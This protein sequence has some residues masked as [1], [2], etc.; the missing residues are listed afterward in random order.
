MSQEK[1]VFASESKALQYLADYTQSRIVIAK[2]ESKIVHWSED[3]DDYDPWVAYDQAESVMKK[4]E[5]RP[6]RNKEISFIALDE[7]DDVIGAAFDSYDHHEKEYSFDV[8]V[9]PEYR[10]GTGIKLIKESL[11]KARE[12]DD[13]RIR[14][15]VVNPK[16]VKLLENKFGF[17]ID[18]QHSDGS[19]HMSKS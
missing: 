19:A 7:N 1:I 8:A 12:L 18:E 13:Y 2:T 10:G 16:L 11:E 5:I 14:L 15:W 4:S 3:D 9:L 6:D 17:E